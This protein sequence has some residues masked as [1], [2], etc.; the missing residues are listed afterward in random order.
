V[1]NKIV[2]PVASQMQVNQIISKPLES[3]VNAILETSL[4]TL[5]AEAIQVIQ[6]SL[7]TDWGL[8]SPV[9]YDT[10]YALLLPIT[11]RPKGSLEFVLQRQNENGSWEGPG[12]YCI[13][14]TLTAVSG[15]LHLVV[16]AAKGQ[17]IGG[18]P[19]QVVDTAG[20]G[21]HF[22]ATHLS[23]NM[24]LPDTVAVEIIVPA[25]V[26]RIGQS[27]EALKSLTVDADRA[28]CSPFWQAVTKFLSLELSPQDD[29]YLQTLRQ[30]VRAG[31]ALP[32]KL[33]HTLEVLGSDI[34]LVR[35]IEA[36]E[37]VYGGS[38]AV[39]LAFLEQQQQTSGESLSVLQTLAARSDGGLPIA[40]IETFERAWVFYNLIQAGIPIPEVLAQNVYNIFR[41]ELG[42]QG[43]GF[44]KKASPDADDTSVVIFVLNQLGYEVEPESL[45]VYQ[46]ENHFR[47]YEGERTPST[48]VNAHILEAFGCYVAHHPKAFSKYQMAIEKIVAYLTSTQAEN[49]TWQDKWHASPYYA[50]TCCVLA[51]H[52]YGL[53]SAINSS[54]E[55]AVNWL[56]ATQRLDGSWGAWDH[57]TLDETAC[58]LQLLLL[59]G[60]PLQNTRLIPA[61]HQGASF[62]NRYKNADLT[63]PVHLP[64][65]H[66]K[67]L[68]EPVRVVH[69]EILSA[70]YLYSKLLVH[71]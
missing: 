65:W 43:I 62:L 34:S 48:T 44:S 61:L 60:E 53:G 24:T 33:H 36:V 25:L 38:P 63:N 26:E 2:V 41:S 11:L 22:L 49:G 5:E 13:V 14:P 17:E 6:D 32:R 47:C 55:R 59:A 54:V 28:V 51:L 23:P 46:E 52:R 37:G 57:G 3:P 18:D 12:D 15:L 70:L 30:A 21:L 9:I 39:S 69:S 19:Q 42:S 29:T 56:L 1:R 64:L 16:E 10:A 67:T 71:L 68:F 20:R 7:S 50:T 8:T 35:D 66:E 58:A 4:N 31:V 27:L 45:L 40:T